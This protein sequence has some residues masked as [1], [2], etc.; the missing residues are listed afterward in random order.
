[1]RAGGGAPPPPLLPPPPP[2]PRPYWVDVSLVYGKVCIHSVGTFRGTSSKT[3]FVE[4]SA[5]SLFVNVFAIRCV[6]RTGFL[7]TFHETSLHC[8]CYPIRTASIHSPYMGGCYPI[9]TAS[10]HSPYM[11]GCYP[12]RAA[13]I[14]SP[15]TGGCLSRVWKRL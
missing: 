4:H 12:I 11:G 14:H 3:R 6:P 10:I 15:Y 7:R 5:W 2:P 13:S 9:R 1:L 8:G